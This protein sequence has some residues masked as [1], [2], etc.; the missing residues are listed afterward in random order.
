MRTIEMLL[1]AANALTLFLS[2]G[3]PKPVIRLW[4]G[5]INLFLFFIHGAF[6]GFRYQMAFSYVFVIL[7]GGYALVKMNGKFIRARLP[8]SIKIAAIGLSVILLAFTS[9]LAYALPVFSLPD[10]TGSYAVG[11]KYVH[12]TDEKRVDPFLNPPS[13]KRE[14]MLKICYPAIPDPSQPYMPYFHDSPRLIRAYAAFYQG[15]PAFFLDHLK[16]IK[17]H[18]KE[19]L[20]VSNEQ[21]RYPVVLFSHGAGTTPELHAA[22]CEDLASHGYVVAAIDHAYVS[23]A[24]DFP[25]RLVSHDEATAEF[26]V[27]EPA[28]IISE[29]MADD[30]RFVMDQLA[31][32]NAGTRESPFQGKLDLTR[33]GAYGHSV[34]GAAAYS[35]TIHDN[36]IKAALNLDG[37]IY[38]TPDNSTA[39]PPFLMLANDRF[40][41]QLL[42]NPEPSDRNL[43]G[44][45]EVVKASGNLYTIQ[46][47]DHM[48]FSDLGLFVG[49]KPLRELIGIGGETDPAKCLEIA[50]AL[51]AAFF[52]RHL[53]GENPDSPEPISLPYPELKRIALKG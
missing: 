24:T 1:L 23:A 26:N 5:G 29:I 11:V 47:S 22:Q 44:L 51:T 27:A 21:A 8:K 32:M 50:N 33:I 52:D 53:K 43:M 34:G 37:F 12:L 14:L 25:D 39:M 3:K 49:V 18:A 16:L 19:N 38:T 31:D 40:H 30:A 28:E 6:E 7:F 2:M 35:L 36:R 46:G 41:I 9:F 48:K 17:T 4:M 13:R 15:L 10:P 42:E 20:Q 45:A